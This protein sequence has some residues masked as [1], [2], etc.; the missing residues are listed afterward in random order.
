M[1]LP[2]V[3]GVFRVMAEPNLRY[4]QGGTAAWSA[5][6]SAGKKR[7][8]QDAYDNFA[9]NVVVFGDQAEPLAGLNITEGSY[10]FIKG[11][12]HQ[13]SYETQQGEKR[14]SNEVNATF[15]HVIPVPPMG[16]QGGQQGGQQAPQNQQAGD[17]FGNPQAMNQGYGN[18]PQGYGQPQGQG[19]G[20]PQGQP[21][22]GY[23][24]Q[25][26][27]GPQQGQQA[28]WQGQPA[29]GQPGQWGGQPGPDQSPF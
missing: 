17:P 14:Q 15:G 3:D 5:R 12:M 9:A 6:L 11:E 20:Q 1:P 2:T 16:Q 10:V 27:P 21:N 29:Q 13:S 18:A 23:P 4:T 28:P 7:K 8:N 24:N 22:Q 25:G 26:Q 19:Y